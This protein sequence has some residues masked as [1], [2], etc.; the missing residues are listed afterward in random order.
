M[1]ANLIS[2]QSASV[3]D[4]SSFNRKLIWCAFRDLLIFS[5]SLKIIFWRTTR[6]KKEEGEYADPLSVM[7]TGCGKS[8]VIPVQN[9]LCKHISCYTCFHTGDF[10][11]VACGGVARSDSFRFL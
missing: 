3:L 1:L 9:V 2:V 11:C 6:Y 4:F 8:S 5:I 7:C 10:A